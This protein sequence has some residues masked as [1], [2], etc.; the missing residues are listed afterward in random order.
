ML[1]KVYLKPKK[2]SVWELSGELV[3]G[4]KFRSMVSSGCQVMVMVE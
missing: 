1:G 4:K 2:S 3:M